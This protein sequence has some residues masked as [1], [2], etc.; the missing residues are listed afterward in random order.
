MRVKHNEAVQ[1]L[2]AKFLEEKNQSHSQ[3]EVQLKELSTEARK[4]C[5]KGKN[6]FKVSKITLK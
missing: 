1:I 5:L 6:L 4:V 3:S 2:K